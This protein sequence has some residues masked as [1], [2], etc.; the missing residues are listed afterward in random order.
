MRFAALAAPLAALSMTSIA[1]AQTLTM[2]T[3]VDLLA[4]YCSAYFGARIQGA[5]NVPGVESVVERDV[6]LRKKIAGYLLPRLNHLDPAGLLTASQQ[7]VNDFTAARNQMTQCLNAC[8][9]RP[10]PQQLICS[11]K[12]GQEN[13]FA[14][15][16]RCRDAAFLPY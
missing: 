7:G 15:F 8:G 11:Q 12:C 14:S 13:Y 10:Q 2:P 4:S 9:A 1:T 16:D 3:D 6:A 5:Q